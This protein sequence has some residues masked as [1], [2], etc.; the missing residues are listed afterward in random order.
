MTTEHETRQ[1]NTAARNTAAQSNL[2]VIDPTSPLIVSI[3][4]FMP[5]RER[6][7]SDETPVAKE[8]THEQMKKMVEEMREQMEVVEAM[9]K[10]LRL[11]G[12]Q[13]FMK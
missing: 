3:V 12:K 7:T 6:D 8:E 11:R 9:K 10:Q 1:P 2:L 4:L 13:P 5:R